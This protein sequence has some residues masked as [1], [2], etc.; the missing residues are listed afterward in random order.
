MSDTPIEQHKPHEKWSDDKKAECAMAVLSCGSIEKAAKQCHI[1]PKTLGHWSRHD[2]RFNEV[3]ENLQGEKLLE[4]RQAYSRVV[5]KALNVAERG[6]DAL[7]G[8][9]LS[10]SDIKA[11]VITGATGT[12]KGLLLDGKPTSISSKGS[13]MAT[14]LAQL[15]AFALDSREKRARVVATQQTAIDGESEMVNS[16][17]GEDLE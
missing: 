1:S 3:L 2:D 14:R 13:D 5:T 17:D 8:K 15:E 7:D 6:I 4:H 11:L 12:D 16:V 9:E 10:A